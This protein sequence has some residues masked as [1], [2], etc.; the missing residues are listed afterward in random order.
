MYPN[1]GKC[2]AGLIVISCAMAFAVVYLKSTSRWWY[3]DDPFQYAYA[4]A[5]SNPFS[6]FVDP[7]VLRGFGTGA[8]V[9]PMQLLSYWFDVHLFGVSPLAASLH[10][11]L[12]TTLTALLLYL[13]LSRFTANAI[14]SACLAVVWLCLPSTI[15]VHSF[16]GTRHYMEGLGWSLA[17]CYWLHRLGERPESDPG[18]RDSAFLLACSCAALLTKE[19]Y[20]IVLPSFLFVYSLARRRHFISVAS[21]A[22]VLAYAG[23]RVAILDPT[24]TY[25]LPRV[26]AGEY[27]RYLSVLPYTLVA[28]RGGYLYYAGLVGG[29]LLLLL[30][31]RPP[32]RG[33]LLFLAGLWLAAL[34]PAYPTATAVLNTYRTPGTWY[35]AVFLHNTMALVAGGYLLVRYVGPHVQVPALCILAGLLLPGVQSTRAYW[36]ERSE[37]SERE[38]K[39][40]LANPDK[41]VYGEEDAAWFLPGLDRLY[42]VARS[43]QINKSEIA[44]EHTKQ[45]LSVFPTIW[46]Y[47]DGRWGTDENLY[48]MIEERNRGRAILRP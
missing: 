30:R 21:V 9:V 18:I 47:R 24:V 17:A 45:M 34:L 8:S 28:H 22:L 5:I 29:C 27:L 32:V 12:S 39:F 44:S 40:Y 25:P 3:E 10:S 42:G 13:V 43:H 48:A 20:V 1:S 6:I 35:R 15:A 31:H 7:T 19:L 33:V 2:W 41:L 38:G 14:A 23:Y 26:H 11:L 4:A 36:E 46:R 16:I 37:R